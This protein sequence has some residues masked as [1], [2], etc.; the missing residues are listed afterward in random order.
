MYKR[1]ISLFFDDTNI[2]ESEK[3]DLKW[4]YD[5]PENIV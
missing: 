3:S 5:I 1:E 4:I 2:M